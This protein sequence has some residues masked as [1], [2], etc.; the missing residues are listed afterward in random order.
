MFEAIIGTECVTWGGL[1]VLNVSQ[2]VFMWLTF[3]N[4][5][6]ISL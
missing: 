4:E 3:L 5:P 2:I 1:F 6:L